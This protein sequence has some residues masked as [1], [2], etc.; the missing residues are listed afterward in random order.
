M[1]DVQVTCIN[2]RDREN[3]HE[4][5][6]HLGGANWKWTRSQVIDSINAMSNTFYTF[7]DGRRADVKVVHGA[8]GDYV[9]TQRDG[10][11]TDNLLALAECV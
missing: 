1:A 9:R 4:S 10:I 5:I 7:N 6:T 11:W 3:R 2:K 8:S